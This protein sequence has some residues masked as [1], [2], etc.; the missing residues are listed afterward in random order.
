MLM[1]NAFKASARRVEDVCAA[2]GFDD[3][4]PV[5]GGFVYDDSCFIE[6][7]TS[8]D[9]DFAAKG[10]FYLLIERSDWISDDRDYL[11]KILWAYHYLFETTEAV[12]LAGDDLDDFI[13]GYCTAENIKVDGDVFGQ[14]FSGG[15]FFTPREASTILFRAADLHGLLA[16]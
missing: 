15:T 14:A 1:F 9:P 4:Q 12:A 3:G 5:H 10:K 11:A 13:Q 7:N 16:A 8:T 6:D 2:I